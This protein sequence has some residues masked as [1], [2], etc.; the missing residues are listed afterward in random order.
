MK[1]FYM[2]NNII[3]FRIAYVLAFIFIFC[4]NTFSKPP[5]ADTVINN[6]KYVDLTSYLGKEFIK[7]YGEKKSSEI[8]YEDLLFSPNGQFLA[9]S[10]MGITKGDPE[11]IWILDLKT[12]KCRLV[13]ELV[14]A[15]IDLSFYHI[16][17]QSET[18][19]KIYLERIYIP[20]Q[21]LNENK[22]LLASIDKTTESNEKMPEYFENENS[23][24]YYKPYSKYYQLSSPDQNNKIELLD[25]RNRKKHYYYCN[26][27]VDFR[28]IFTKE[29]QWTSDDK[30]FVFMTNIIHRECSLYIGVTSPRFRIFEL[31]N[32]DSGLVYDVSPSSAEIAYAKGFDSCMVIYDT[33]KQKIVQKVKTGHYPSKI[34]WG[35]N[36]VIVFVSNKMGVKKSY[37]D[38]PQ[39]LYM[40]ELK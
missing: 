11:Q 15:E 31:V 14:N 13:T 12:K 30:Q 8:Y 17:W 25:N 9:I 35:K 5:S 7:T 38:D 21:S 18:L 33:S 6:L 20:N 2:K 37:L 4:N 40:V 39:R 19:L 27:G 26:G 3:D 24:N 23:A 28:D 36:K 10:I 34:S 22:I 29:L 32:S 16:G 1:A